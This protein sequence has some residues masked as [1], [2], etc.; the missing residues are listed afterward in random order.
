MKYEL[1]ITYIDRE[2]KHAQVLNVI[3]RET[4]EEILEFILDVNS[5]IADSKFFYVDY[6]LKEI[7]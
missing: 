2:T 6:K 1:T 4:K 5:H 3:K 7:K